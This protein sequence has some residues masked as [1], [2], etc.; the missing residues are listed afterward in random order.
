MFLL[1]FFIG[2]TCTILYPFFVNHRLSWENPIPC[3]KTLQAHVPTWRR[4]QSSYSHGRR[5]V[6]VGKYW[7]LRVLR[8]YD[9]ILLKMGIII[10]VYLNISII[11]LNSCLEVVL[12]PQK[13][14]PTRKS[15]DN[16]VQLN[17]IVPRLS[18]SHNLKSKDC[19]E[20]I[21]RY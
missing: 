2:N 17:S 9:Q 21:K 12:P 4:Q 13:W 11:Y 7:K 19:N 6:Y 5:G 3:E 16:G 8:K 18:T 15:S 14:K 1:L 20:D 10:F